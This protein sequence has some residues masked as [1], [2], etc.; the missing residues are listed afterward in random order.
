MQTLRSGQP[1]P[2]VTLGLSNVS[3]GVKPHARQ[4]LNSVYLDEAIKRGVTSAILNASKIK[5]VNQIPP[6]ELQMA[7]DVIYDRREFAA[8]GECTYDP[9]FKFV[10][11][12]TKT[13]G[14][15]AMTADAELALPIEERLKKRIID[16]KKIGVEKHWTRARQ[17]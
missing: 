13:V 15:V 7:L 14:V 12:F 16:G 3:F 11:H 9:L 4:V 17:R 5:P 10:D 6:D 2:A 8:D 1:V